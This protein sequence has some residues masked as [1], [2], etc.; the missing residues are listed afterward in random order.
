VASNSASEANSNAAS[1]ANII[2]CG[3]LT[4][5]YGS[6][7]I[8]RCGPK[9]NGLPPSRCSPRRKSLGGLQ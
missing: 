9:S 7:Q 1:E 6:R 3:C 5:F 8:D 4:D 2:F